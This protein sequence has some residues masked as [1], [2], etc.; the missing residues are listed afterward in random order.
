LFVHFDFGASS[1][2]TH[3]RFNHLRTTCLVPDM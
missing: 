2:C 1:E 3:W